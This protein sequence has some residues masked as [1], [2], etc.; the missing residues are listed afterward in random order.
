[1]PSSSTFV[2]AM[3]RHGRRTARWNQRSRCGACSEPGAEHSF[4]LPGPLALTVDLSEVDAEIRITCNWAVWGYGSLSVFR[5]IIFV[6]TDAVFHFGPSR[7]L[8]VSETIWCMR[9]SALTRRC[10]AAPITWAHC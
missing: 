10:F 6:F 1:M 8:L 4:S 3:S 7:S 2:C 5:P 9:P